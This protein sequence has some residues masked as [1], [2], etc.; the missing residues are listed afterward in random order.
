MTL[1]SKHSFSPLLFIVEITP[2]LPELWHVRQFSDNLD[3]ANFVLT[4]VFGSEMVLK[5]Y[6]LGIWCYFRDKF[7]IFDFVIVITSFIEIGLAP[8]RFLS[9]VV[10]HAGGATA[11]RTFRLL[12]IF[13]LAR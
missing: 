7:N 3:I 11:L 6:G 2:H 10:A 13:K 1:A 12:R 4:L 9:G 5:L 8:P